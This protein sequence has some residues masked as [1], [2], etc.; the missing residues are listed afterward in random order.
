[1]EK[2]EEKLKR[3]KAEVLKQKSRRLVCPI[4]GAPA[5]LRLKDGAN[6]CREGGHITYVDGRVWLQG[7]DTTLKEMRES[8]V[9]LHIDREEV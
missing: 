5:R 9:D 1:M 3:K 7:I 2:E 8:G 6:I 4:C